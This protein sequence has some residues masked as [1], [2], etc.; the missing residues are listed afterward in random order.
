MPC[1]LDLLHLGFRL[2]SP[3]RTACSHVYRFLIFHLH[4]Y[5]VSVCR[6][7]EVTFV[8]AVVKVLP[9]IA[10]YKYGIGTVRL[11]D[12]FEKHPA[13]DESEFIWLYGSLCRSAEIR[14]ESRILLNEIRF[15]LLRISGEGCSGSESR[16]KNQCTK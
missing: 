9:D 4:G 12:W 13:A 7:L 16:Y 14:S 10:V 15:L 6:D 1:E 5:L 2:N 11:A 3:H 8:P